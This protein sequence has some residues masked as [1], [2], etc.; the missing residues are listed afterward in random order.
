MVLRYTSDLA[1]A[2]PN[3]MQMVWFGASGPT[4]DRLAGARLLGAVMRVFSRGKVRLRS[5]D[6]VSIPIV[7]FDML[8]DDRDRVRLRDCVRR[9]I[10]AVRHPAVAGDQRR[11]CWRRR[12]RST[13]STPT[14]RSTPGSR[15]T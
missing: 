2:G 9:M 15:R 14:T 3:D 4:D 5:D 11:S 7:D 12:H 13:T 8:S 1:G 10:D 6:P